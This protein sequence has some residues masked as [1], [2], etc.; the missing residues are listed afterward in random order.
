MQ[1]QTVIPGYATTCTVVG[2][3]YVVLGGWLVTQGARR[4]M[5]PFGVP[6]S[7]LASPHFADFFQFTFVH[8][9]VL[10]VVFILLGHFV[11]SGLHQRTVARVLCAIECMYAALDFHTSDSPLGTGLYQGAASVVPA[12]IDVVVV[13]AFARLALRSLRLS[14]PGTD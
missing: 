6:E 1:Q 11:T 3:F 4:A 10:G 7:T 2:G 14:A 9:M 12:L 5:A 8:T 13:L